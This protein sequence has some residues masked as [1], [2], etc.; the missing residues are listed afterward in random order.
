M[1]NDC[2]M[3][4]VD[5]IKIIAVLW[6]LCGAVTLV[7][8]RK[9]FKRQTYEAVDKLV[10]KQQPVTQMWQVQ[11]ILFIMTMVFWPVVW[12]GRLIDVK[13][14]RKHSTD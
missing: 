1:T 13:N 8:F 12:I 4:G 11:F 14:K 3:C 9:N 7:Y 6:L 10:E 2:I 5:M